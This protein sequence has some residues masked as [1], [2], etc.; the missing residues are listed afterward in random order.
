M[1]RAAADPTSLRPVLRA[2]PYGTAPGLG[3]LGAVPRD[4]GRAEWHARP[5]VD[6]AGGPAGTI[7]TA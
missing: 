6:G 1:T 5:R 4:A 7:Q 3:D 2:A